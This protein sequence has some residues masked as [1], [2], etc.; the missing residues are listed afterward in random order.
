MLHRRHKAVG[1]AVAAEGAVG[2]DGRRA[3][4][5]NQ[6]TGVARTLAACEPGAAE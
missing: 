5:L 1:G 3:R 6:G 2:D 4:V